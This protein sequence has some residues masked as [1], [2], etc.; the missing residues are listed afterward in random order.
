MAMG[1][2]GTVNVTPEMINSAKD[3]I[4]EYQDTVKTLYSQLEDTMSALIPGNFSGSA[5]DGFKAFYD[6]NIKA[7]ANT[8]ANDSGVM[9]IITLMNNIVDGISEAIPAEQGV[10]ESLATENRKN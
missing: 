8:D 10:D 3:A 5:A 6:N 7:V 9:Q 4:Q 2:T 1:S